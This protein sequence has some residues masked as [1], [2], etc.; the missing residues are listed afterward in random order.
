MCEI[1]LLTVAEIIIANIMG[2]ILLSLV[3]HLIMRLKVQYSYR[4]DITIGVQFV[5]FLVRANVYERYKVVNQGWKERA[6][7]LN[8]G[9]GLRKS[10]S[11][12]PYIIVMVEK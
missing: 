6:S 3:C 12:T 5:S 8:L 11:S 10:Q 1:I 7:T 2:F 4:R 9:V